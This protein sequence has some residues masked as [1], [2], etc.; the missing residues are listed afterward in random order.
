MIRGIPGIHTLARGQDLTATVLT[1]P[2]DGPLHDRPPGGGQHRDPH[3]SRHGGGRLNRPN[4]CVL[5]RGR[6]VEV[7][8]TL[9]IF[10]LLQPMTISVAFN[11]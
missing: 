2:I 1:V 3:R 11:E 10:T 9:R 7:I 4:L 5:R 8:C 6:E